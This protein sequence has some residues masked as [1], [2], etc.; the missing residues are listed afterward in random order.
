MIQFSEH[1]GRSMKDAII[2]TGARTHYDTV[3]AE[4]E[5]LDRI[6]GKQGENYRVLKQGLL[7]A[8]QKHYD[9]VKIR[10]A[11]DVHKTFFFDITESYDKFVI[12]PQ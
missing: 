6:F 1:S 5:Y 11:S 12:Y 10:L 2:I 9:V 8:D 3:A 7:K 4:Y